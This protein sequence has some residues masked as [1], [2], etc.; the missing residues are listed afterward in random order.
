MSK[1]F[2]INLANKSE[3]LNSNQK[4]HLPRKHVR[5]KFMEVKTN[6]PKL[7]QHQIAT[8]LGFSDCTIKIYRKGMNLD[9]LITEI[10][11]KGRSQSP[12]VNCPHYY[13]REK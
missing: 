5:L 1:N 9:I 7:T 3:T 4:L 10:N 13:I 11:P 12:S 2:T 6:V 8:E